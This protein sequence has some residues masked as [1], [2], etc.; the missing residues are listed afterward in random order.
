MATMNISLPDSMKSWVERQTQCGRYGNA[1]DYMR[2]LIR[3]DQE[4]AAAIA[5]LQSIVDEAIASGETEAT[6]DEILAEARAEHVARGQ[7]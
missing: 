5:D 2:D 7:A 3:R 1:S 6:L 4:R